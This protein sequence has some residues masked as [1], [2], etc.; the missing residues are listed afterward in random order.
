[1]ETANIVF[2]L[3]HLHPEICKTTT[4]DATDVKDE[5][6]VLS[7]EEEEGGVHVP[8]DV[9]ADSQ[10]SFT[11]TQY[12]KLDVLME[13]CADGVDVKEEDVKNSDGF[14]TDHT[15]QKVDD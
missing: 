8:V 14:M 11:A 9:T 4:I 13:L 15:E 12:E 1:M 10:V 3:Q 7:K 6:E 2:L 5:V